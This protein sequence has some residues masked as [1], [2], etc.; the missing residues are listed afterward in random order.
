MTV[1]NDKLEETDQIQEGSARVPPVLWLIYLVLIVI[2]AIY[3]ATHLV[4]PS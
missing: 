3:F 4:R 1:N 2:C